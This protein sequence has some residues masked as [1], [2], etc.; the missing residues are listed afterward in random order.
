MNKKILI[1][2]DQPE[3]L[4][5]IATLLKESH[6]SFEIMKAP[7][8]S[9]ALKLIEKKIPDLII[10]DWEMP[11]MDGIEFIKQLRKDII[12][13][14]IPVI[15][16]TGVMLTSENL[17]TALQAGAS[18]Y[19]RKPVDKIELIARTSSMLQL[20]DSKQRIKEQNAKL[21]QQNDEILTINDSLFEKQEIITKQ[22]KSLE[23]TLQEQ[24]KL[25]ERITSSIN[26]AK[27][28]QTAI[29]PS[30]ETIKEILDEYFIFFKPRNILSGDFYWIR[31]IKQHILLAAVDCT[32]HGVP[33]AF[34]SMLGVSF[35]NEIVERKEIIE[36]AQALEEL[37]T[38]V[39]ATLHQTGKKN[40]TADGMDIAFCSI[41][42]ETNRLQYAGAYNP[43][44]LIRDNELIE[45]K[46]TRSP[47]GFYANEK[48]FKNIEIQLEKNDLIYLFSDGFPDQ[49]GGENNTK[50]LTK[51]FKKLLLEIHKLPISEQELKLATVFQNWKGQEEQTDDIIIFGIKI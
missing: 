43:L 30:S 14:D 41:N 36:P 29:L 51:N 49:F 21:E 48:E 12:T 47:V 13:V 10:T 7:N 44:I 8:G 9:I 26:Y 33:G 46:A 18:D 50:F 35:M 3:N 17:Q 39:K 45:Y 37:R 27:R 28:I 23:I 20:S 6:C 24:Q 11:V 32:G 5:A 40:D 31:K 22:K 2:D 16:C 38:K 42:T 15:M 34:M 19:I 25:N 1:V 4:Q